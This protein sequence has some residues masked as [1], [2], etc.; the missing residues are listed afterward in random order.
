MEYYDSHIKRTEG[1][2]LPASLYKALLGIS[3][4]G[5][6]RFPTCIL[7]VTVLTGKVHSKGQFHGCYHLVKKLCRT[8]DFRTITPCSLVGGTNLTKNILP[9]SSP[10]AGGETVGIQARPPRVVV[11]IPTKLRL[12]T[13]GGAHPAAY[14]MG[15]GVPSGRKSGRG[16]H[17][18]THLHPMQSV[19]NGR[20]HLP[21]FPPT[22]LHGT[23]R[24]NFTYPALLMIWGY[25]EMTPSTDWQY[26]QTFR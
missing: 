7:H 8:V 25:W 26:S 4:R 17:S 6:E 3:L 19:T 13:S 24:N 10:L 2:M 15:T 20:S 22:C 23:Y 21:L 16:A 12:R 5:T 14:S 11:R 1:S 9:L 18:A